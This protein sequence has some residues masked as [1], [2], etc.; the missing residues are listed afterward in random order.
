MGNAA[1]RDRD[2]DIADCVMASPPMRRLE[3]RLL[4]ASARSYGKFSQLIEFGTA[5]LISIRPVW[6]HSK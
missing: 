4:A 3:R 6:I 2:R 5:R 1:I